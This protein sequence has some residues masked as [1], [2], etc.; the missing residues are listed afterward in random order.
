MGL[1]RPDKFR[2][3]AVRIALTRG[4]RFGSRH[5]DAEQMGH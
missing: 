5:I 3:D 1:K 2:A 4:L